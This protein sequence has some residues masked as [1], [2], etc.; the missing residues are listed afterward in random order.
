M[1]TRLSLSAPES[2]PE[3]DES[4]EHVSAHESE[5][6]LVEL[7]GPDSFDPGDERRWHREQDRERTETD[8]RSRPGGEDVGVVQ[9]RQRDD[10]ARKKHDAD[11]LDALDSRVL[12]C[13]EWALVPNARRR[14]GHAANGSR[15]RSLTAIG[16]SRSTSRSTRTTLGR[17]GASWCFAPVVVVHSALICGR[18]RCTAVRV[19]FTDHADVPQRSC[20][21]YLGHRISA[22][23]NISPPLFVLSIPQT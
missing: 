21:P 3:L 19:R 13:G 6:A 23:L 20:P 12:A 8:Q 7:A 2:R 15:P 18:V 5:D 4:R 17:S 1:L 14:L 11:E 22:Y 16:T 10:D 9:Q